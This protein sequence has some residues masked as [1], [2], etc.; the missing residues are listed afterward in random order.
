VLTRL[1][2]SSAYIG[3]S[4]F[5]LVSDELY[6]PTLLVD[7]WLHFIS[8]NTCLQTDSGLFEWMNNHSA[9]NTNIKTYETVMKL[10]AWPT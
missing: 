4:L 5:V 2:C 7:C 6:R 3:C 10:S 8:V 1:C 9:A